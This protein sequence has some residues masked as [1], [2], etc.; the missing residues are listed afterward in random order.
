MKL[1][2]ERAVDSHFTVLKTPPKPLVAGENQN[3]MHRSQVQRHTANSLQRTNTGEDDFPKQSERDT[4]A[5]GNENVDITYQDK[6]KTTPPDIQAHIS[7]NVYN[8]NQREYSR[9]GENNYEKKQNIMA[10]NEHR[11][12]VSKEQKVVK[13]NNPQLVHQSPS[14]HQRKS[15][16]GV[17]DKILHKASTTNDRTTMSWNNDKIPKQPIMN[18]Q[19]MDSKKR[20]TFENKPNVPYNHMQSTSISDM[21]RN[22]MNKEMNNYND[23]KN[24]IVHSRIGNHEELVDMNETPYAVFYRMNPEHL[25][26]HEILIENPLG[27]PSNG[28]FGDKR[29][30]DMKNQENPNKSKSK[31]APNGRIHKKV[32]NHTSYRNH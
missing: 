22:Y 27:E 2:N 21:V 8:Y 28:A 1:V 13:P 15:G 19:K 20:E 11:A 9:S 17:K 5:S 24:N 23:Y 32:K 10:V 30:W 4:S 18:L 7:N 12:P 25:D 3:I 6:E 26:E 31:R 29:T 14:L 16:T